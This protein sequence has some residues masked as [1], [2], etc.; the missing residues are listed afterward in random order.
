MKVDEAV[1]LLAGAV[2]ET[3]GGQWADLGAGDGTFT[4]ALAR[5]LGPNAHILAIDRDHEA[6]L[7]LES[8]A[9]AARISRRITTA[10]ADFTKP[11]GVPGVNVRLDGMLFANS[12][13]F[14]R[15]V[16]SLLGRLVP[17]LRPKGRVVL[18]EYDQR[19]ASR[20]VPYPINADRLPA[21][22]DAA[23]LSAP[24]V[25]ARRPSDYGGELYVAYADAR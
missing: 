18:V 2:A 21:L 4:I 24:T 6:L 12:L 25:T 17:L 20:W 1:E 3:S 10:T 13:H 22:C 19:P 23:G 14:V 7:E 11:P 16:E 9:A 15:D 8:R 5:V